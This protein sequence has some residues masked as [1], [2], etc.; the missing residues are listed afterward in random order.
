ME[1]Y[2]FYNIARLT[3]SFFAKTERD[4]INTFY[5]GLGFGIAL[6]L[7]FFILQGFGLYTMA[8][9]RGYEKK[10]LAFVPFVN[11]WYMGKLAGNCNFFGQKVKRAGM[12]AMIAQIITAVLSLMVLAAEMY[13]W[14][15]HGVPEITEMGS[16][17]WTGLKGFSLTVAQFYD[18]SGYLLSIF[19][20]IYEILLVVLLIGLYRRYTPKNYMTLGILT[21]FVPASRYIVIFVLRNR[22][23]IDYEAYMR[24]RR[25]AYMRQQQQYYNRYDNPYNN[26]YN[27]PYG[28]QYGNGNSRSAPEEPFAE[29][30]STNNSE[31]NGDSDGFFD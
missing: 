30:S 16:A 28:S 15:R 4:L 10:V 20:L 25:E 22:Q 6:W 12:Y 18:L 8:K 27:N 9:K 11:I 29:F 17:Y 21:L 13:L 7:V 1:L 31:N 5:W 2:Y 24:A 23:S 26:P 14:V 19:Q 3:A